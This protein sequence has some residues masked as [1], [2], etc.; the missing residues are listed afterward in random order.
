MS[1]V[2]YDKAIVERYSVIILGWPE[3]IPMISPQRSTPLTTFERSE[4][5]GGLE[6]RAGIS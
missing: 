6:R 3:G 1:Y 4:S 5:R 2:N